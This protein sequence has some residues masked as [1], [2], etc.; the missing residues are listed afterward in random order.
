MHLTEHVAAELWWHRCRC[1]VRIHRVRLPGT[2]PIP[3]SCVDV[4]CTRRRSRPSVAS[5]PLTGAV[6]HDWVGGRYCG[7][8]TCL[9]S[10]FFNESRPGP[11]RRLGRGRGVSLVAADHRW[12]AAPSGYWGSTCQQ[13]PLMFIVIPPP[14]DLCGRS[15]PGA[16]VES[17]GERI[18]SR[19]NSR[20]GVRNLCR[21]S[22]CAAPFGRCAQVIRR[23]S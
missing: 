4:W 11:S 16:S 20:V 5:A 15:A 7:V 12:G 22:L 19:W 1:D 17:A 3:A 2:L 18:C 14:G 8:T 10:P 21:S 13:S 6:A 9:N 23:I